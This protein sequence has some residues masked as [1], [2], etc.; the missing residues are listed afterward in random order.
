MSN[1][2][3]NAIAHLYCGHCG[4]IDDVQ[5]V[6]LKPEVRHLCKPCRIKILEWI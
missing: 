3:E 2:Q 4:G 1:D 5:E 6:D